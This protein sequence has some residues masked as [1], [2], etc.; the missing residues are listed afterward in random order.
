MIIHTVLLRPKPETSDEEIATVLAHVQDLQQTI[1]GILQ[2]QV[3][4]NLNSSNNHGYTYGFVMRFASKEHLRD[5]APH[6]VHRL[7]SDEL[8]R[9]SQSI[10]DF[11]LEV[12]S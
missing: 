6:P 4:P 8:V 9:I 5:Y 7:V 10:I 1:P 3:G 12:A 11:D 2:V